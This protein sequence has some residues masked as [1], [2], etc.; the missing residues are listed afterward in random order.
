M[1]MHLDR[2]IYWQSPRCGIGGKFFSSS[3]KLA[4]QNSIIWCQL[5]PKSMSMFVKKNWCNLIATICSPPVYFL[6]FPLLTPCFNIRVQGQKQIPQSPNGQYNGD[7]LPISPSHNICVQQ[8]YLDYLS[9]FS[10]DI[11]LLQI[12]IDFY[13]PSHITRYHHLA[14]ACGKTG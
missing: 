3:L 6:P 14:T 7:Q 5:K 12:P 11:R 1:L 9:S 13:G 2:E 10:S 8:K 4:I